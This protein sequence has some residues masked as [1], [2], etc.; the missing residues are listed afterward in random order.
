MLTQL[1]ALGPGVDLAA[2]LA[3]L[4]VDAGQEELALAGVSWEE[5]MRVL[6]GAGIALGEG[7][8]STEPAGDAS[9]RAG[10]GGPYGD[11]AG[12]GEGRGEGATNGYGG[13]QGGGGEGGALG[14]RSAH[15]GGG[16]PRRRMSCWGGAY[17]GLAGPWRRH[18]H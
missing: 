18:H 15:R 8:V 5:A 17:A 11:S 2:V 13:G 14:G 4:S 3:A 12:R 9:L 6:V 7:E 10:A 16:I 1:P